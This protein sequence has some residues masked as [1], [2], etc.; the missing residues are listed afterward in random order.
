M[1][2]HQSPTSSTSPKERLTTIVH[3]I[4]FSSRPSLGSAPDNALA[5]A[6]RTTPL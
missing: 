2:H 4:N 3:R 5:L 6:I 1:T